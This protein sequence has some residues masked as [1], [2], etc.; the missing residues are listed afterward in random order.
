M[1]WGRRVNWIFGPRDCHPERMF[2]FA[3]EEEHSRRIPA[4]SGG[5][6]VEV[7]CRGYGY[8]DS[9]GFRKRKP[10]LAQHDRTDLRLVFLAFGAFV[11]F[12][13]FRF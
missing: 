5:E 4:S 13:L 7:F 1:Q 2:F 3:C 10:S 12:V 11:R 6:T 9:V 8:F